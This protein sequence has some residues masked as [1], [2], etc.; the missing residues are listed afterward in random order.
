MNKDSIQYLK[1]AFHFYRLFYMLTDRYAS[2][3]SMSR[4]VEIDDRNQTAAGNGGG[5]GRGEKKE[6]FFIF[7]VW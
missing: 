2:C 7:K 1:F 6:I 3:P 5:R 4:C